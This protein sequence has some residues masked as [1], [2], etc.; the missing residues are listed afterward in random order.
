MKNLG[1]LITFSVGI[2][3]TMIGCTREKMQGDILSNLNG[4]WTVN[5]ASIRNREAKTGSKVR[6]LDQL[7]NQ[8]YIFNSEK[9]I[10]RRSN[11]GDTLNSGKFKIQPTDRVNYVLFVDY[12]NKNGITDKRE[13]WEIIYGRGRKIVAF[14][15]T[16][17]GEIKLMLEKK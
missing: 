12:Q 4:Q 9:A 13:Y 8:T 10:L 1:F 17:S 5:Q 7:N 11:L 2:V 3:L 14:I 15:E 6:D 16:D